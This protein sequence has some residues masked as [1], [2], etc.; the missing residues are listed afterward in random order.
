MPPAVGDRL[1]CVFAALAL[2]SA[3]GGCATPA[4]TELPPGARVIDGEK[5]VVL[6]PVVGSHMKRRVRIID[7]KEPGISPTKTDIITADTDTTVLPATTS[8]VQQAVSAA[9]PR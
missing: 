8:E 1:R 7:L 4:T 2:A 5:Y 6:E 3:L 9:P